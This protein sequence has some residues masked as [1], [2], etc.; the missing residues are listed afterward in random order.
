MKHQKQNSDFVKNRNYL[1]FYALLLSA[2]HWHFF[3][4]NFIIIEEYLLS[5][6]G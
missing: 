5:K 4:R 6:K 1:F 3:T 2:D